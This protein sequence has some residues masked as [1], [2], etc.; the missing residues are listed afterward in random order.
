MIIMLA[1]VM[2]IDGNFLFMP[3]GTVLVDGASLLLHILYSRTK[4]SQ[5]I[6]LSSL[7]KNLSFG[8]FLADFA[9]QVLKMCSKMKV[10]ELKVIPVKK[11][12]Y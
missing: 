10:I 7:F 6:V 12:T 2:L 5:V 8:D 1:M 11:I 3:F 4:G 9:V